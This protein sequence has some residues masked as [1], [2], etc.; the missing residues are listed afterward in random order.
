MD[1]AVQQQSRQLN[2]SGIQTFINNGYP[3]TVR[4]IPNQA[5]ALHVLF[6][7]RRFTEATARRI[8]GA[9]EMLL[10][11]IVEHPTISVG[12]IARTLNDYENQARREHQQ[13]FKT[14]RG[15]KLRNIRRKA[16]S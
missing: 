3:L 8:L 1:A 6:D 4:I 10:T 9:I 16:I 2:L 14:V 13:V 15:D 11:A 12:E 7:S 5:V